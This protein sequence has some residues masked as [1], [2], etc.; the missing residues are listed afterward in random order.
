MGELLGVGFGIGN[1]WGYKGG[2]K[3]RREKGGK[4]R[5]GITS[6]L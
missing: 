4:K 1:S 6:L 3:M 5:I 2:S